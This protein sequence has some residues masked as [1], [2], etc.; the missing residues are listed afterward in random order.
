MA[1]AVRK[2]YV[3]LIVGFALLF[4][5][6]RNPRR[7]GALLNGLP[8]LVQATLPD[9]RTAKLRAKFRRR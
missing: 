6:C 4:R 1:F 8:V 2:P 7:N 9:P 3:F 5:P